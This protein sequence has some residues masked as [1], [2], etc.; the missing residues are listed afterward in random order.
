MSAVW[1]GVVEIGGKLVIG[2]D[3]A[4]AIL[5]LF[6]FS[7]SQFNDAV[8]CLPSENRATMS[9]RELEAEKTLEVLFQPIYALQGLVSHSRRTRKSKGLRGPHED[10]VA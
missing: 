6:A 7:V 10:D 4:E 1:D 3:E 5:E 9:A 8:D 2:D